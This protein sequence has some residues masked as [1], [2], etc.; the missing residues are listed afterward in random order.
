MEKPGSPTGGEDLPNPERRLVLAGLAA[1]GVTTL[2]PVLHAQP[3]TTASPEAAFGV[4]SRILTGRDSLDGQLASRLY[5]ALATGNAQF[6][7]DVQALATW[8]SQRQVAADQ[9]QSTLD[10][11]N[12]PLASLPRTIAMAWYTGIVGENEN[13]RSVAFETALMHVVVA[14]RLSPPSYCYGSPG[15]WTAEPGSGGAHG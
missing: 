1:V 2:V 15:S 8:I 7:A 11:E 5:E 12:P 10:A 14:D 3:A 4:I 6:A 13:A 9:L